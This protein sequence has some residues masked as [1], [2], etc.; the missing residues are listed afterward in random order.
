MLRQQQKLMIERRIRINQFF[1]PCV[2][3]LDLHWNAR[4]DVVF[5][6]LLD[7]QCVLVEGMR[8]FEVFML[9]Q[10]LCLLPTHSIYYEIQ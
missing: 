4:L 8:A 5:A 9:D 1:L 7:Y 6:A 3:L 2:V 10:C